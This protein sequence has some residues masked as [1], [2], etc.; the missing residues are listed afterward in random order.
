MTEKK[1]ILTQNWMDWSA[2]WAVLLSVS[3]LELSLLLSLLVAADS[4]VAAAPPLTRSDDVMM[5]CWMNGT[6]ANLAPL[7]PFLFALTAADGGNSACTL[8]CCA[9]ARAESRYEQ[10]DSSNSS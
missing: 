7:T 5:D 6:L 10:E 4:L 8:P 1:H 2:L 9:N 3:V